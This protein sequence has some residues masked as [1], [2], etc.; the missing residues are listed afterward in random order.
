MRILLAVLMCFV[1]TGSECFAIGGGP[2]YNPGNVSVT[3]TYA[4]V[5]YPSGDIRNTIGLF[6]VTVPKSGL[7]SGTAFLFANSNAYTGTMQATADPD[8][9]VLTGFIDTGFN[10]IDIRCTANC[11]DPDTTKRTITTT[12][13]RAEGSGVVNGT[14]SS[15]KHTFSSASARLTGSALIEF[16]PDFFFT[17]GITY[18]VVGFK[19]TSL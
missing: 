2:V 6:S 1:L 14:V 5:L 15:N 16:N 7:G 13:V 3:G 4:G 12:A 17:G 11:T 19:Q 9:A 18:S 10:F 8:S